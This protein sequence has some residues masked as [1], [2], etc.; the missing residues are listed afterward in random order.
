[1]QPIRLRFVALF[2]I[3]ISLMVC[4]VII[5]VPAAH[6]MEDYKA[7]TAAQLAAQ[8]PVPEKAFILKASGDH[9]ALWREGAQRPY[10]VLRSELWL[11][12]EEDRQ[13]VEEGISVYTEGEL[14]QLLEDLGA[15]E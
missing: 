14:M 1:M 8:P 3:L 7:E 15:E 6:R 4:A 11:L 2:S 9:L 12:S 5:M 10:R 13:A